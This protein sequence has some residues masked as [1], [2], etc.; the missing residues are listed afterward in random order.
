MLSCCRCRPK[1]V[2]EGER[3]TIELSSSSGSPEDIEKVITRRI[4]EKC[5]EII[6]DA[7]ATDL[8][9][10]NEETVKNFYRAM[11][12]FQST[13]DSTHISIDEKPDLKPSLDVLGNLKIQLT[14]MKAALGLI[15]KKVS[16]F[17]TRCPRR[18]SKLGTSAD[19]FCGPFCNWCICMVFIPASKAKRG[20]WGYFYDY[21]CL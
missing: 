2:E 9:D 5:R 13:N 1:D 16:T 6:K 17:D 11:H 20:G 8:K 15:I 18:W 4:N 10:V 3:L 12:A 19:F 21:Y 7:E 14:H